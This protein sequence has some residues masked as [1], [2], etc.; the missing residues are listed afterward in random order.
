MRK[1]RFRDAGSTSTILALAESLEPGRPARSGGVAFHVRER[2]A[3]RL[4]SMAGLRGFGSNGVDH[5][6]GGSTPRCQD[7]AYG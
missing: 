6:R 3:G 7:E 2:V 5:L 1:V 4:P